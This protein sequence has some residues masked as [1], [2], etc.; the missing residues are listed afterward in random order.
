M[1][2]LAFGLI[3]VIAL[4]A[5]AC[6][7]QTPEVQEPE[8]P[9]DGTPVLVQRGGVYEFD[10]VTPRPPATVR[11]EMEL[12]RGVVVTLTTP[13]GWTPRRVGNAVWMAYGTARA[14]F[15]IYPPRR[16]GHVEQIREYHELDDE[17]SGEVSEL[18]SFDS[19]REPYLYTITRT[20][21]GRSGLM[22]A[23]LTEAGDEDS[24]IVVTG[25]WPTAMDNDLR[26]IVVDAINSVRLST[27]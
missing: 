10:S 25:I 7:A 15:V 21:D 2:R 20:R 19:E 26:P 24:G 14:R 3:T 5:L 12:E 27:R 9:A 13:E 1:T 4:A 17:I 18:H 6:G 23:L 22:Y 11:H 16:G 8:I